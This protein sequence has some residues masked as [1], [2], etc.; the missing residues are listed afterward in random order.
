M[1]YKPKKKLRSVV[2]CYQGVK[3]KGGANRIL[4]KIGFSISIKVIGLCNIID[5]DSALLKEIC[6]TRI[7]RF[8]A[9]KMR[10]R[11]KE[12]KSYCKKNIPQD[13]CMSSFH[14]SSS[15]NLV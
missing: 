8:I 7:F 6:S 11:I 2:H 14:Q 15:H 13:K 9:H 5:S 1:K 10:L 3:Q 12:K 4:S